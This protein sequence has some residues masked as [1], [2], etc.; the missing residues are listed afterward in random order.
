MKL[1]V[2]ICVLLSLLFLS[3]CQ[4][5]SQVAQAGQPARVY[6]STVDPAFT[7]PQLGLRY[8]KFSVPAGA[9]NVR[10]QGHFS[11]SGGERNDIEV[12]LMTDDEFVNWQNH[13]PV[14]TIYSSQ[15]VTQ[16]TVNASLPSDAG[17]YYLIFNN[18]FSPISPKAV[19]DNLTLQYTK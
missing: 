15:K 18:K 4:Q 19:Q 14:T 9:I 5:Q 10:V 13:H 11:A 1:M 3:A 8:H 7:V 17:T 12:A 2:F 16:G 6:T